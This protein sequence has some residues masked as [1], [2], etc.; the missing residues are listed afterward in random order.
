MAS[1]SRHEF[2]IQVH[3]HIE[4]T[5]PQCPKDKVSNANMTHRVDPGRAK[6]RK[7]AQAIYSMLSAVPSAQMNTTSALEF[8]PRISFAKA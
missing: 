3:V 1:N 6:A 5:K 2:N 8:L 4:Q 7:S